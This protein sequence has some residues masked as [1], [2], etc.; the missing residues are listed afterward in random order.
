MPGVSV[1]LDQLTERF[2]HPSVRVMARELSQLARDFERGALAWPALAQLPARYGAVLPGLETIEAALHQRRWFRRRAVDQG[3]WLC[4]ARTVQGTLRASG[5]F[6][7]PPAGAPHPASVIALRLVWGAER[8]A[9]LPTVILKPPAAPFLEQLARLP[10]PERH[11]PPQQLDR[12]ATAWLQEIQPTSGQGTLLLSIA[13]IHGFVCV[14]AACRVVGQMRAE[15]ALEDVAAGY[16]A[17]ASLLRASPQQLTG[18][19]SGWWS[20]SDRQLG[21]RPHTKT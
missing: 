18:I 21:R 20:P 13:D 5:D 6:E 8:F 15:L 14:V 1:P 2:A 19:S 16:L 9:E 4:F 3:D 7:Q 17:W 11:A 10:A 12:A